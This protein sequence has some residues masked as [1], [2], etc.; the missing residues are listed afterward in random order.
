MSLDWSFMVVTSA[1]T[2][3]GAAVAVLRRGDTPETEAPLRDE[4]FSREQLVE[5]ARFLGAA[6]EVAPGLR[7]GQPLLRR[8]KASARV[9]FE[10]YQAIVRA[11]GAQEAITPAAE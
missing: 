5:H 11:A 9:L 2:L 10:T 1:A 7:R 8:V 3:T 6:H 4:L